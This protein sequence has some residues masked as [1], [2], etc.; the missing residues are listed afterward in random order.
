MNHRLEIEGKTIDEAINK[1]CRE[2]GM[3]REKLQIEILA[4][5]TT[6]FFGLVGMKKAKIRASIMSI[7]MSPLE[8]AAPKQ[9]PQRETNHLRNQRLPQPDRSL[10]SITGK[11]TTPLRNL[12]PSKPQMTDEAYAGKAKFFLEGLL[13]RMGVDFTVTLMETDDAH[14]LN[15]EGDGSGLLIG[16]G[17]QTLDALQYLVTKTLG[18]E[19][20]EDKKIVV[21]TENY[22]EKR[23]L[24]LVELAQKLSEKAK[25]KRKPVIVNPMNAHD[26]RIIHL[27]LQDDE[28]VTTKSR[29]EGPFRK[30]VII[31]TAAQRHAKNGG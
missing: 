5:E 30:I 25:K 14:V 2:L 26:R 17:G 18:L 15:I 23:K 11:E 7:D 28:G 12:Q 29:G 10:P 16:K 1:A 13:S 31:P 6:G 9:K 19:G 20:T 22:R 3:P 4:E 27:A 24:A 21:N 8:S